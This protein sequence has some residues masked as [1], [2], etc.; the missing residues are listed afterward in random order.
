MRIQVLIS[1][2]QI[3]SATKRAQNIITNKKK[4][5]KRRIKKLKQWVCKTSPKDKNLRKLV[6]KK[7]KRVEELTDLESP[8]KPPS[9]ALQ[10]P[11][12]FRAEV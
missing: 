11:L 1:F 7:T 3:F 4:K 9:L 12:W 6:F 10:Q 2:L 8:R 5:K